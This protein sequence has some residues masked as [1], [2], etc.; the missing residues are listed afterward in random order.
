MAFK[1]PPSG[2]ERL[3]PKRS[4]GLKLSVL[5]EDPITLILILTMTTT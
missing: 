1:C 2:V 4:L 5:Q 3:M